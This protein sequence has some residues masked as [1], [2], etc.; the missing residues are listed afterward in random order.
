MVSDG[1][2][3]G[4]PQD[5]PAWQQPGWFGRVWFKLTK[6]GSFRKPT[7]PIYRTS[8]VGSGGDPAALAQAV[9][10]ISRDW[11]FSQIV[12]AHGAVPYRGGE[13]G[14]ARTAF[15]AAWFQGCSLPESD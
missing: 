8:R 6:G 7:L 10:G 11:A 12:F 13:A 3:G 2:Y 9:A 15:R 14:D 5:A 4:Y 1:F